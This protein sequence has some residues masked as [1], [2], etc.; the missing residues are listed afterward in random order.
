MYHQGSSFERD[1]LL[2]WLNSFSNVVGVVV[3]ENKIKRKIDRLRAEYRRSGIAGTIDAILFRVYDSLRNTSRQQKISDLINKKSQAYEELDDTPVQYVETPNNEETKQFLHELDPDMVIARVKLL[4]NEEIF[5]IPSTGTFA[6]HPGI[7]PEYRNAHGCFWAI[8]EDDYDNIGYTLLKID[9]GVDTG[10][11]YAQGGIEFGPLEDHVYL[12]FKV[13]SDN[14]D[15]IRSGLES[16][17]KGERDS[18]DISGRE[19]GVWG[20]PKLTD[21]VRL[22]R[23]EKK[24]KQ[25]AQR[26]ICLLYHDIVS[27]DMSDTS[28]LKGPSVWRYKLT[29]SRF[30]NHL[31][32]LAKQSAPVRNIEECQPSKAASGIYLTFDDGGRSLFENAAP[33]LEKY[34]MRGH[35]SVITDR[36]G[37]G[38]FLD[39]EQIS[40]LAERGHHI[41]SHTVTHPDLVTCDPPVR[42]V[43]LKESKSV[44]EDITG[45]DCVSL[46]IPGGKYNDAVLEAAQEAGYKFVFTSDPEIDPANETLGRWN[47]WN[48]TNADEL[49]AILHQN[50]IKTST[51]RARWRVLKAIKGLIGRDRFAK[52]RDTI[53]S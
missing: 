42:E 45:R 51:I 35:I 12:Q 30:E 21:Q 34:E 52:I 43:E 1:L 40:L 19:S 48:S 8:V 44:L 41:V 39:R 24:R 9:S 26:T 5:S 33:L 15:E 27:D 50:F 31:Q 47:V 38:G 53:I 28:G 29:P 25:T 3:V 22:I 49:E 20:Q 18:L 36:I 23:R 13:I 6:I 10:P 46:S 14:L 16:A 4:L 32:Q 17:Y 7:C 11:I 37:E 2:P